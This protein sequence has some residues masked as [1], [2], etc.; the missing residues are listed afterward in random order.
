MKPLHR[1]LLIGIIVVPAAV[2][3]M[4]IQGSHLAVSPADAKNPLT[5]VTP[6]N[7]VVPSGYSMTAVA[8]GLNFPTALTFYGGKI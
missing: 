3:G 8:T 6:S 4:L 5:N 2:I 1:A 7:A